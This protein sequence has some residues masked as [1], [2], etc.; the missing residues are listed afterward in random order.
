MTRKDI[1]RIKKVSFLTVLFKF[2]TFNNE[3]YDF[4]IKKMNI[5]SKKVSI[6]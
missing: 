3:K 5:R 2:I 1:K 6:F 4:F